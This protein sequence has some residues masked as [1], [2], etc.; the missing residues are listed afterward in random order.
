M[1]TRRASNL[2]LFIQRHLCRAL[3][4]HVLNFVGARSRGAVV[5]A[6]GAGGCASAA[7]RGGKCVGFAG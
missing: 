5:K 6:R 1:P 4:A 3:A 2:V 7:T